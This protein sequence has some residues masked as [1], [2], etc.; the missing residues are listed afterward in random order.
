[1]KKLNK[2]I[3]AFNRKK[4]LV[5]NA[6]IISLTEE[7]N[8]ERNLLLFTLLDELKEYGYYLSVDVMN[9]ISKDEI[10]NLHKTIIPYLFDKYNFGGRKYKPLYPGF[11]KQVIS[12][13]RYELKVDQLKVYS[14]NLD[15]FIDNNPWIENIS[16]GKK[17]V[18][19]PTK[20]LKLMTDKEFMEIPK[21]ELLI[22]QFFDFVL[23]I[24]SKKRQV[25]HFR[26]KTVVC[27]ERLVQVFQKP[28]FKA[29][30]FSICSA[31]VMAS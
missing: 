15:E 13:S 26:R 22:D 19:D 20:E 2:D 12:K 3:I 11:P 23:R 7:K 18:K 24:F 10:E 5:N 17:V 31:I 25:P 14:G 28:A 30:F 4:V 8:S 27:Y 1:M 6:D 9:K 16:T 21:R 29:P